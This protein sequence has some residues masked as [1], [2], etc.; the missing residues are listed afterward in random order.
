MEGGKQIEKRTEFQMNEIEENSKI[1]KRNTCNDTAPLVL[2]WEWPQEI[3][4]ILLG[5]FFKA[6][7]TPRSPRIS[8]TVSKEYPSLKRTDLPSAPPRIASNLYLQNK[9]V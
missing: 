3:Y 9:S 8:A 5:I 6:C 7:R 1:Q 2:T 4:N